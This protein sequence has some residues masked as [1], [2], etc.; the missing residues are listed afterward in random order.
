MPRN[1]SA[2]TNPESQNKNAAASSDDVDKI[3]D[4]IFGGQMRE[5]AIRFEQLEKT[6]GATIEGFS[7]EMEKR[8]EG[9]DRRLAADQEERNDADATVRAQLHTLEETLDGKVAE[10]DERVTSE[11]EKFHRV[12]AEGLHA[13]TA[14]LENT[15]E[16]LSQGLN[17]A[18]EKL[19]RDKLDSE[20]LAQLFTDA[21]RALKR[22]PK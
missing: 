14:L 7:K 16:E 8:F 9:L 2:P 22:D 18:T 19:D 12:L 13:L 20:N 6:V 1:G 21:A 15:K 17:A 3:R 10:T 4:I 5:Y 11:V